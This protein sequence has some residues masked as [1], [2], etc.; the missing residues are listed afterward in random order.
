[1]D[2][3]HKRTNPGCAQSKIKQTFK[4]HILFVSY[5]E[6]VTVQCTVVVLCRVRVVRI[7][8]NYTLPV[9]VSPTIHMPFLKVHCS[10]TVIKVN[11]ITLPFYASLY[12]FD[13]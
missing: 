4:P 10:I 8:N 9:L 13:F 12:S 7:V 1:M 3:V 11:S 6:S 5:R 2:K